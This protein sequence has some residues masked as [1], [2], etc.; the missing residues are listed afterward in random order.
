MVDE[1][2]DPEPSLMA[3]VARLHI[4]PQSLDSFNYQSPTVVFGSGFRPSGSGRNGLC[5][6][7]LCRSFRAEDSK[8]EGE[9]KLK[10]G[11]GVWKCL[12]STLL[13]GVGLRSRHT[14][15]YKKAVAKV[16]EVCSSVSTLFTVTGFHSSNNFLS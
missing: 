5:S 16:E 13:G 7:Q 11:S 1:L 3:M 6:R 14:E 2:S 15:E 12:R 8:E 9:V 4:C 10:K